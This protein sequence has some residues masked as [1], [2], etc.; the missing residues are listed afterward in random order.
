MKMGS[1]SMYRN[2]IEIIQSFV[3]LD[4]ALAEKIKQGRK[5]LKVQVRTWKG[6]AT[7]SGDDP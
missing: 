4:E 5:A 3:E 7:G 1:G 2:P 6:V